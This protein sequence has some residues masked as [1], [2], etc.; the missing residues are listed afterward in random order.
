VPGAAYINK[1]Q[2]IS[3]LFRRFRIRA[4][5]LVALAY[6]IIF[7]LLVCCYRLKKACLIIA[8]PLLAALLAM[9][10]TGCLSSTVN[11]FHIVSLVLILGIGSDY[12]IFFAQGASKELTTAAAVSLCAIATILSFGLLWLSSTPVLSSFGAT[13]FFGIIFALL[14]APLPTLDR[15]DTRDERK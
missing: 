14:F 7:A 1:V 11:F 10:I 2:S 12:A 4:A 15:A 5:K 6:L 3:D 8:S 9:G 13:L